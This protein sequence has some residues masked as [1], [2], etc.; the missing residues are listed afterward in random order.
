MSTRFNIFCFVKRGEWGDIGDEDPKEVYSGAPRS[1]FF[2]SVLFV[3]GAVDLEEDKRAGKGPIGVLEDQV[4]RWCS[5][6]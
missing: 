4:P 1:V 6:N 3:F 5:H 2:V